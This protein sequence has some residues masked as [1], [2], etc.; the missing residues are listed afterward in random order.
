MLTVGL[1][2]VPVAAL[3]QRLISQVLAAEVPT[4][5]MVSSL[6]LYCLNS[7]TTLKVSMAQA[8]HDL[9][10]QLAEGGVQ[11]GDEGQRVV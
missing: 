6:V 8:V 9:C 10:T 5:S 2:G 7:V 4:M 1:L 11:Y 3:T